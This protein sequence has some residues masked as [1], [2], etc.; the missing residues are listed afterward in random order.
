VYVVAA[1]HEAVSVFVVA[2]QVVGE[3]MTAERFGYMVA[4]GAQA[5]VGNINELY[6]RRHHRYTS[7]MGLAQRIPA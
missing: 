7:G 5:T 1:T 4:D 3:A 2:A 6:G